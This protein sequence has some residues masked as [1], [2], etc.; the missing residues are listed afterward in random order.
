MWRIAEAKPWRLSL[1]SLAEATVI[2]LDIPARL[3]PSARLRTSWPPGPMAYPRGQKWTEGDLR[4]SSLLGQKTWRQVSLAAETCLSSS[5]NQELFLHLY[6]VGLGFYS[7]WDNSGMNWTGALFLPTG[8][9][10]YHPPLKL[11]PGLVPITGCH[12][13]QSQLPM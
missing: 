12:S 4:S 10:V 13:A 11:G 7:N 5:C 9:Q 2:R 6:K 1:M 8:I 3:L